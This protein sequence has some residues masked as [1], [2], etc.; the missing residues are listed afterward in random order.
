MGLPARTPRTITN[1][2]KLETQLL[3]V[4]RDGYG[5]TLEE[6]EIGLNSLS[7]PRTTTWVP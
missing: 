2:N 3:D 6:F 7:V 1:R 5:V 4:A